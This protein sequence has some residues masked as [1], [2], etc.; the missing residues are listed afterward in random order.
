MKIVGFLI[1][2]WL[3]S[4]VAPA[5]E[6]KWNYDKLAAKRTKTNPR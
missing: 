3:L 2:F 1:A 6:L 4:G 5:Q